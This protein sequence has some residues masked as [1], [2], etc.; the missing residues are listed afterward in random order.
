MIIKYSYTVK[1]YRIYRVHYLG[2]FQVKK[3]IPWKEMETLNSLSSCAKSN[4]ALP[5]ISDQCLLDNKLILQ[6]TLQSSNKKWPVVT[7][8]PRSKNDDSIRWPF[9]AQWFM[10]AS[11]FS[12][13]H[14]PSM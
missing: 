3:S 11:I 9:T 7:E 6:E 13:S 1:R 10:M 4:K 8:S 14:Y 12:Y 5:E 2:F